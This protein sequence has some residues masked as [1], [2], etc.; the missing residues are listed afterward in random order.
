MALIAKYSGKSRRELKNLYTEACTEAINADAKIYREMG[1]DASSFLRS[2]AFSNAL[3]VGI[4]SANGLFNNLCKVAANTATGAF[5]RYLAR[6]Y[7]QVLSGAFTPQE[8]TY[9]AVHEVE[10]T[11]HLGARPS[12]AA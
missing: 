10:V 9:N 4:K 3:K 5:E 6:A 12:H 8:A 2:V 7:A 1:K 11:S